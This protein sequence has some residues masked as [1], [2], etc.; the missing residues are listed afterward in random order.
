MIDIHGSPGQRGMLYGRTSRGRIERTISV[1]GKAFEDAGVGWER[2]KE[3]ARRFLE[4]IADY[5]SSYVEELEG[6]ARGAEADFDSILA[7]NARTEVL[8]WRAGEEKRSFA[9]PDECTGIVATGEATADGRTLHAQNWDWRADCLDCAVVLRV[10]A[11]DRHP[12]ILTFT[13]AGLLA[14][15]GLNR[16]GLALTANGLQTETDFGRTGV[17]IPC[18]RRKILEADNLAKALA[19]VAN[20]KRAFSNNLMISTADGEAINLEVTPEEIFWIYPESGLVVHTNHFKSPAARSKVTDRIVELGPDT[21]L[22]DLR[23]SRA[24]SSKIGSITLSDVEEALKDKTGAPFSVCRPRNER[25]TGYWS[26]TVATVIL[27][28]TERRMLIEPL[29]YENHG[30]QEYCFE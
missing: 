16:C 13:E 28:P 10:A 17:P 2:A 21:L 24:L 25:R 1:Y 26:A 4:P 5:E 20:A 23:T 9:P 19:A 15:S 22:R 11:T 3:I 18:I 6:I 7:I 12:A 29:P 8:F 30:F 27:F 14:R